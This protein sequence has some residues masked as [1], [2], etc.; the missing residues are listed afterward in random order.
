MKRGFIYRATVAANWFRSTRLLVRRVWRGPGVEELPDDGGVAG[1]GGVV[2]RRHPELVG[3]VRVRVEVY[4]NL[5]EITSN[6]S[7]S[8]E[9]NRT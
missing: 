8:D 4:Q 2:Q 5:R 1:D 7:F 9:A 3:A 6:I